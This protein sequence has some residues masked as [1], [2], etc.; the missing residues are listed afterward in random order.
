M[1]CFHFTIFVVLETTIS[2][3]YCCCCCCDLL[4]FYYLCRTGNNFKKLHN[5]AVIVVI[6]FHFTIFVVLET[7]PGGFGGCARTLWFAF[8]LLS[9]SYWKQP[10]WDGSTAV[11]GCDLLSFYYL[12]RT[13]NNR[14]GCAV[15]FWCVVI[16][17]HFT[18]FVVLETTKTVP[19]IPLLLLWFAFILLSL[20]YWKQLWMKCSVR[21]TRCD[22]LSFYYLCRTGNNAKASFSSWYSVVICFHFTIFVVLETTLYDVIGA[23]MCCD[24]LS[25]YY[26]CRTGNNGRANKFPVAGVVICFHFT[27]FVVLETTISVSFTLWEVL[28]FAFILLS[29][30]YW[31]QRAWFPSHPPTGCDLLSFYYLCRTGNN[32]IYII[33]CISARY[34]D[35]W[36]TKN[37]VSDRM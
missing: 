24:L 22:L 31:K 30:S 10:V 29:L 26:L 28:W 19:G 35:N 11:T 1:I 4:S 3:L 6:C 36:N 21:S 9:L 37:V 12:C 13:G 17:F 16:C 27:I 33:R 34:K 23:D 14:R 20:S 18:I 8:I 2:V 15:F 5:R 25:F 32:R 7:T